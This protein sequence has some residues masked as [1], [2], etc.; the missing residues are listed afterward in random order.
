MRDARQHSQLSTFKESK[1]ARPSFVGTCSQFENYECSFLDRFLHLSFI[2][3]VKNNLGYM[4]F[5]SVPAPEK[6]LAIIPP[7]IIVRGEVESNVL[8][9]CLP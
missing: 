5:S 6:T 4:K 8:N 7:F 1:R 3:G 9:T 2:E